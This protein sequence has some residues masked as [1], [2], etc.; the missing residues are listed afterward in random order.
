MFPNFEKP[1]EYMHEQMTWKQADRLLKESGYV[2]E[3]FVSTF[4]VKF[5]KLQIKGFHDKGAHL[6]ER[7]TIIRAQQQSP[8]RVKL[9]QI[10]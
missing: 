8:R 7:N 4:Y 9:E 1:D 3:N 6:Y 2:F 5:G 10:I